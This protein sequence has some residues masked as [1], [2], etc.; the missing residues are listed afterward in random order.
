MKNVFPLII[1]IVLLASCKKSESDFIWERSYGK[2]TALFVRTSADSGL[3]SSGEVTGK[4][5]IIRL[6]NTRKLI[7]EYKGEVAGL[8][9]SA[10]S[11]TSGYIA[12]GNSGGKMLLTRL[13]RSGIKLW[14][15]TLDAGFNVDYSKLFYT[16]NGAL[17][18]IGTASPDSSGSGPTGL[19]FVRFDTT[20]NIINIKKITE[21]AFISSNS[22]V[23]DNSGNFFLAVTRKGVSSKSKASVAK[24]NDQLQKLWETDLFNNPDFGAASLA[25]RTDGSGNVFVAGKTELSSA[26]GMLCSSFL[27]S[28]NPAGSVI[29]KRYLEKSN[30]GSS[31]ILDGTTNLMMLNKNCFILNI[32]NPVD[33]TDAGRIRTLSLC[34]SENTDALG[35]DMD[36]SYDKYLMIAGSRGGSFYLAMKSYR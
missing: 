3:I 4:P 7:L 28:L 36:I 12:A 33:G 5:Y 13:G 10:W 16:G 30:E 2:G 26:N 1:V 34:S 20:G 18:A 6:N 35:S 11:D 21:P 19:L 25:I 15:K 32:L 17:L 29:W 14:D 8:F 9:S 23:V 31:L 27:A 22:A 24:F